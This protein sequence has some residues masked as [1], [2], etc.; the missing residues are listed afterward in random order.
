MIWV[1]VAVV[2]VPCGV[3]LGGGLP[4][5]GPRYVIG[6][7]ATTTSPPATSTTQPISTTTTSPVLAAIPVVAFDG[8]SLTFGARASEGEAYPD[9]VLRDRRLKIDTSANFGVLA[10][11]MAAMLED[12]DQVDALFAPGGIVVVWEGTN[13]LYFGATAE[14]SL[15]RLR[16]YCERRRA[17]GWKVLV[18][19]VLPRSDPGT[20]ADFE[21]QRVALN[22]GIRDEWS[23][24]ADGV[25]DVAAD[26]RLGTPSDGDYYSDDLV[27][28]T[29][30]GYKVVALIAADALI[31]LAT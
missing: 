2:G 29:D 18:G 12:D 24:F 31:S 22:A 3:V 14:E 27:H 9:Q 7:V 15:N 4:T 17:A 19:T 13:D 10:Q 5:S 16:T 26:Q 1:A 20:P 11:N 23:S 30:D 21:E 8:N 6:A 28:L 25:M